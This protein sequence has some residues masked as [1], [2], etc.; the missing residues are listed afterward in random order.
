MAGVLASKPCR[1]CLETKK[2][3]KMQNEKDHGG[4]ED[5]AACLP[6]DVHVHQGG[7]IARFATTAR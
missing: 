4:A 2:K 6:L 7:E 3:K 1:L 5:V